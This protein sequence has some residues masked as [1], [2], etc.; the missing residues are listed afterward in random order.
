M[1][2]LG[3]LLIV[4]DEPR[5]LKRAADNAILAGF[6]EVEGKTT[7]Q[8]ALQYLEDQMAAG[9]ELPDGILLDLDFGQDSGYELIRQWHSNPRLHAIP[10]IVWSILGED[11][12]TVCNL[13]K[14]KHF[15]GKWEGNEALQEALKSIVEPVK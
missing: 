11:H 2:R 10:L 12:K 5:D 4:E 7:P 9:R 13:F 14:I 8:A 1:D 3:R 15:I 6:S